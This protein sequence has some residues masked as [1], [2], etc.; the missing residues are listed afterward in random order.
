MKGIYTNEE[1]D[2][3]DIRFHKSSNY[4]ILVQDFKQG[5]Q[6]TNVE[7][8]TTYIDD[9]FQLLERIKSNMV[10]E[11]VVIIRF[12]KDNPMNSSSHTPL[13]TQQQCGQ[14]N[15]ATSQKAKGTQKGLQVDLTPLASFLKQQQSS[16]TCWICGR[17]HPKKNVHKKTR[18]NVKFQ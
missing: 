7:C 2:Q 10:E 13:F 8:H 16:V 3:C 18:G 4:P 9:V 15:K 6:A 1:V 14:P 12:N 11:H 17:D 5:T